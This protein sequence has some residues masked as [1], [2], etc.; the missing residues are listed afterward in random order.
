MAIRFI[1]KIT[2]PD[3]NKIR[4]LPDAAGIAYDTVTGQLF[5]NDAGTLRS[6]TAGVSA[7]VAATTTLA[8]ASA[9]HAGK[10]VT[11][12]AVAGFTT[13]LPAATGSGAKYRLVVATTLTSAA[14]IVAP[15]GNDLMFG[16]VI[17]NNTGDSTPTE[18][19]F[20]PTAVDSN[21][22]TFAFS[23]GAGVKGDWVEFEDIA[24]DSWA[25]SGA[26]QAGV[27]PTSPFSAV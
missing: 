3:T 13:T 2:T 10:T 16:G 23:A 17:V 26:I 25:V 14:Y 20:F 27:D 19:D 4:N 18:A 11:L 7:P 24:A 6:L 21:T 8:L 1:D 12:G 5:Y 22:F 9:T 15:T